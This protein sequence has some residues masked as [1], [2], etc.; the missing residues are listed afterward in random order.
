MI[1]GLTKDN[2]IIWG[3]TKGDLLGKIEYYNN[4]NYFLSGYTKEDASFTEER[5]APVDIKYD[6]NER[7]DEIKYRS[8]GA[9]NY[10]NEGYIYELK[11]HMH[12][13]KF[14]KPIY[15]NFFDNL[16]I[17]WDIK[18][19]KKP[20]TFYKKKCR[21]TSEFKNTDDRKKYKW[22]ADLDYD[23]AYAVMYKTEK[24]IYLPLNKEQRIRCKEWL[25][26]K[27]RLLED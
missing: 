17:V 21:I 5:Y 15:I 24:N 12:M 20:L 2:T 18:K 14:K 10:I 6:D 23:D 3:V 1:S 11:K 16:C 27:K 26:E 25:K 22:V 4:I 13:K 19:L 8:I 9:E 7:V